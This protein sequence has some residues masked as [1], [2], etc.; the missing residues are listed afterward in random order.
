[1]SETLTPEDAMIP[2]LLLEQFLCD[3][4]PRAEHD[5]LQA[6]LTRSP[7]ASARLELLR[8]EH[9]RLRARYP[10]AV[11]AAQ[12]QTRRDAVAAR[13]P[14]T[15][16]LRAGGAAAALTLAASLAAVVW[17]PS[18]PKPAP[19]VLTDTTRVK[20]LEHG[21]VIHRARG[22]EAQRL[23]DE[24]VVRAG[25]T[26]QLGWRLE[27]DAYAAIYSLDGRGV[28]TRH[29]PAS[30]D[31]A[32]TLGQSRGSLAVA[33]QLDDAPRFERF[34][35]ITSEAPFALKPV[36]NAITALASD[37]N[38]AA[39]APLTLPSPLTTRALLVRKENP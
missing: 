20:G 29:F 5:A 35:L 1:M 37:L 33:Y 2:D 3:D 23:Q 8:Q 12:I 10:S 9:A 28:V 17:W 24:A 4:L 26:L 7:E 31:D 27:G 32:K 16:R 11:Q 15:R 21:L 39:Q 25:D 14:T 34:F 38:E 30:G 6:R 22:D 18:P 36:H 19:H 13:A